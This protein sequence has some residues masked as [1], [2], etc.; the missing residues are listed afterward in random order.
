MKEFMIL[1]FTVATLAMAASLASGMAYADETFDVHVP[2]GSVQMTKKT[3]SSP[4]VLSVDSDEL[5]LESAYF[6]RVETFSGNS[7]LIFLS[8]ETHA[9]AGY[10]TW[11]TLD[12]LGLRASPQFGNC[13]DRGKVMFT[14]QGPVLSLPP[15]KDASE[16]VFSLNKDG[17]VT[18]SGNE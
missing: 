3:A 12:E 9:C 2:L 13:S 10:Y 7:F 16:A 17:T 5:V 1:R 14:P 15:T 18:K 6:P 4:L 11:V 8:S